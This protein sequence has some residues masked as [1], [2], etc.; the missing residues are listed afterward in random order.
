ML[1][2]K[3]LQKDPINSFFEKVFFRKNQVRKIKIFF[4]KKGRKALYRAKLSYKIIIFLFS[5]TSTAEMFDNLINFD[6]VNFEH[7]ENKS[8]SEEEDFNTLDFFQGKDKEFSASMK[9][10]DDFS[11]DIIENKPLEKHPELKQSLKEIDDYYVH[12][13]KWENTEKKCA[14]ALRRLNRLYDHIMKS[15]PDLPLVQCYYYHNMQNLQNQYQMPYLEYAREKQNSEENEPVNLY[16]ISCSSPM[17]K[18]YDYPELPLPHEQNHVNTILAPQESQV[19]FIFIPVANVNFQQNMSP[20]QN[21]IYPNI[22]PIQPQYYFL[23]MYPQYP[24]P[25]APPNPQMNGGQYPY[26]NP[27]QSFQTSVYYQN[28][29]MMAPKP[30]AYGQPVIY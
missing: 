8:S 10:L 11:H 20:G 16:N 6:D 22:N 30:F 23:N 12:Q 7:K 25:T 15:L 29:G 14:S 18:M 27:P 5:L 1:S 26:M 3:E 21:V 19:P 9:A 17:Q 28:S 2:T 4:E 13:M 24:P